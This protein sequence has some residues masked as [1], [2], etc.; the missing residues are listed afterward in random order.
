MRIAYLSQ[1]VLISDSANSVHV[2][3]MAQAMSDLGHVLH[4]FA[5]QGRGADADIAAHYGVR[6]GFK[7]HRFDESS[8]RISGWLWRLRAALPWLRV[9]YLPSIIFG[10]ETVR[11]E[12]EGLAPDLIY[13]RNIPWLVGSFTAGR[14]FVLESHH[15]PR[16]W[17]DRQL[18]AWLLQRPECHGLVVISDALREMYTGVFGAAIASRI[19]VAHDGADPVSE[20]AD[21]TI[22]AGRLAIG[23]VG[24][25]YEGRG[26]ELIAELALQLPDC[27]FHI[28]GGTPEDIRRIRGRG[29]AENLHFHGHVPRAEVDAHLRQF[30]IVLAPYQAQVAVQG[31]GNTVAFMSPMKIFEYMAWGKPMICSDLP[32]LHEVLVDS[33]N[34]LLVPPKD[35]VAWRRAIERL[36]DPDLRR[37][38]GNQAR[39]DMEEKFSWRGRARA[40]LQQLAAA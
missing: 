5:L 20:A 7:V 8:G 27:D 21:S 11:R 9:G 30:D 34:A 25:L 29:E 33:S 26:G 6:P 17:L 36:R 3:R 16:G 24:H 13:A 39:K 14:P 10:R 12:L 22:T 31:G 32:V 23:Y 40:I 2:T 19:V 15:P 35:V 28:V 4:L 18:Q 37:R 1:S 38:L